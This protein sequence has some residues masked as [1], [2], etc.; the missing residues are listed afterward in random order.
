VSDLIAFL[1]ARLDEDEA[2][3]RVAEEEI[4]DARWRQS[5]CAIVAVADPSTLPKPPFGLAGL[6]TDA[7]VTECIWHAVRWDPAR[8]LAEVTA[9]R[10]VLALCEPWGLAEDVAVLRLLAQPHAAHP[11]FD[12]AWRIS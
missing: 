1:R 6:V 3:A 7:M 12:P 8:V 4:G 11:D 2:A 10:A 5:S 9:K